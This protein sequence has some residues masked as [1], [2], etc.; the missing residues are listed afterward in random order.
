MA[1]NMPIQGTAADIMKIAM[2][3][4]HER[5]RASRLDALLCLQ[6]HDE[7]VLDVAKGDVD[8]V[9]SLVCDEMS[10]AYQL[11]VPVVVDVRTGHNWDEMTRIASPVHA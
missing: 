2:I 8:A 1:I 3:R 7:L 11:D 5:M 4:V 9:V 10:G 6:V